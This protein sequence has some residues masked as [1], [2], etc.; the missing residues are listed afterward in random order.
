MLCLFNISHF[1][2]TA[3]TAAMAQRAQQ[4]SGEE[5][6]TAKSKPMMNP[7]ARKPSFVSSSASSNPGTISY[8]YQDPE[9]YVLDD[10]TGQPV[11]TSRSNY[12][13]KDY[14]RSWSSQEWKSGAAEHDRSGKPEEISW[15]T[16]QKVAPHREEPLRVVPVHTETHGGVFESTHVVF[17]RA[18]P[19]GTHTTT[20]TKATTTHNDTTDHTTNTTCTPAHNRTQHHTQHHTETETE[21]EDRERREE[22]NE[23]KTRQDEGED[24]REEDRCH[25]VG[26]EAGLNRRKQLK[27]DRNQFT[28]S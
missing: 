27:S 24:E 22:E 3:C 16:L 25:D 21:K 10:R 28:E 14:G 5:R 8:G 18:T 15:D 9:R 4:E 2:S 7:I 23:D 12:L 13:Q 19:H 6:V 20:T 26:W 17:Q 1:S 11:E